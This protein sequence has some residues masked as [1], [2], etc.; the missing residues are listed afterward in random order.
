MSD[1]LVIIAA[2]SSGCR[3]W[4]DGE[5]EFGVAAERLRELAE[6]DKA[7]RV[8]VLPEG[9]ERMEAMKDGN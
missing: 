3:R 7:G 2:A 6:A 4:S 5:A 9:G 8:V 1:V